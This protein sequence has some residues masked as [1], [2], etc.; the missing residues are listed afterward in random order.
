MLQILDPHL[1]PIPPANDPTS[2][3][4]YKDHID[5][6]Q[7]YFKVR[8]LMIFDGILMI[9]MFSLQTQTKIAYLSKHK[10][11][12]LQEMT[13]EERIKRLEILSKLKDKVRYFFSIFS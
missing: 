12:I 4:I 11:A 10:E 1:R 13:P 9:F 5:L 7:E 2:Q 3:K 6:A 8:K